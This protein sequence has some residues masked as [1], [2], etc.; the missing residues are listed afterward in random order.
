L[1]ENTVWKYP[2]YA[3]YLPSGAKP[4]LFCLRL[5]LRSLSVQIATQDVT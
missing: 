5:L 4:G 1:K 2:Q 3:I